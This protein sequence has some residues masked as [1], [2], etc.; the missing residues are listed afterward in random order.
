MPLPDP[1]K[2][3]PVNDTV[4]ADATS[5]LLNVAVAVPVTLTGSTEYGLP[6]VLSAPKLAVAADS[7]AAVPDTDAVVVP[8]YTLFALDSP[9]T[10]SDLAVTFALVAGAPTSDSE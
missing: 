7:N 10:V 2:L 1:V 6:S 9:L 4:V 8:S 3:K 5:L